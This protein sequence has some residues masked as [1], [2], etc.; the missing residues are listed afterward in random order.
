MIRTVAVAI[1]VGLS[2]PLAVLAHELTHAA[3]AAVVGRDVRLRLRP[4]P[5]VSARYRTPVASWAVAA[6]PLVIGLS[7]ALAVVSHDLVPTGVGLL[8]A[9]PWAVY[10]LGGGLE[11]FR[12]DGTGR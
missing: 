2:V 10:T 11:E 7:V 1:A 5:T 6:A 4:Q 9:I 3:V 8:A 12:F